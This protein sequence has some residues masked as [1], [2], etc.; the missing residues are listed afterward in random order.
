MGLGARPG[1]LRHR[2]AQKLRRGRSRERLPPHAGAM[3]GRLVPQGHLDGPPVR[4]LRR[5]GVIRRRLVPTV[6]LHDRCGRPSRGATL[7]TP[8]RPRCISLAHS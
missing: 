6:H 5:A 2:G 7:T 8:V 1:I 4:V 3:N